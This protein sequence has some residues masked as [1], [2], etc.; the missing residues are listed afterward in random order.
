MNLDQL[1]TIILAAGGLGTTSFGIVQALKWTRFIGE[2]GYSKIPRTLGALMEAIRQAYG[3]ESDRLLRAQY[4]KDRTEH[5]ELGRMLRQGV[6]AGLTEKNAE[7]LAGFL[8]VTDP[9]K[10]RAAAQILRAPANPEEI[11]PE[12]RGALGRFD[13]AVDARIDA[14]LALAADVYAGGA[15]SWASVVSIGIAL[16]AASVMSYVDGR[17]ERLGYALLIGASAVPIAPVANDLAGALRSVARAFPAR[18]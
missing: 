8:G 3:P 10:L 12:V 6:R 5:K 16:M 14:A 13:L 7:Q 4:R 1:T 15:R 2:L 18:P 9:E 11:S 17:W